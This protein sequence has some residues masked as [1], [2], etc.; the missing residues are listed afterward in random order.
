MSVSSDVLDHELRDERPRVDAPNALRTPISEARSR[1]RLRLTLT[2]LT[3]GSAMNSSAEATR[4]SVSLDPGVVRV[5]A[6]GEWQTRG[7]S[8]SNGVSSGA[9]ER[10]VLPSVGQLGLRRRRG[11]ELLADD[12][13]VVARLRA[14]TTAWKSPMI[15]RL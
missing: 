14:S 3:A 15:S 4:N 9:D 13:Q 5:R 10:L 8:P 11:V 7:R 6:V 1:M 2:R 12:R